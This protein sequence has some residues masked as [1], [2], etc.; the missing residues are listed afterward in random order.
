M[1]AKEAL[2]RRIDDM[3]DDEAAELLD[4][5]EWESN[6]PETLTPEE[7]AE[8]LPGEEEARRGEVVDGDA[9]LRKYGI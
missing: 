5:L 6:E 1:T 4:R 3:T 9:L 7:L 8:V 2:R